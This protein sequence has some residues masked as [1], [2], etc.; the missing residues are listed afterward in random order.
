MIDFLKRRS[1]DLV[2]MFITQLA[3]SIFGMALALATAANHS[4]LQTCTSVFAILFYLYLIYAKVWELGYKESR[5]I[6]RGEIGIT[7]LEG[8]YMGLFASVINFI[9]ALLITVGIAFPTSE[10]CGS[11]GAVAKVI[12]LLT[13]GMYTGLLA[14]KVG[15]VSLNSMWFMYFIIMIPLI[16]TA[17]LAYYAGSKG[18]KLFGNGKDKENS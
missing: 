8:L 18:F 1:Y 13:E 14:L 4:T 2:H 10:M 16:L 15:G 11:I 9:L 7:R 5:I 12:A 3:I 6:E 17:F